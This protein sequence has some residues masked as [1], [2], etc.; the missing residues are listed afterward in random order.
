MTDTVTVL[1]KKA[2]ML[3]QIVQ[4]VIIALI[5][6]LA[7]WMFYTIDELQLKVAAIESSNKENMAQWKALTDLSDRVKKNEIETVVSQRMFQML[8][9]QNGI[10][11]NLGKDREQEDDG[12]D[13]EKDLKEEYKSL[14]QNSRNDRIDAFKE[15]QI[16]D[17]TRQQTQQMPMFKK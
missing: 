12:D 16:R 1:K 17:F 9:D 4:T 2:G 10:R 8:L 11:I 13:L 7:S 14:P 5:L 6:G 15:E 3:W